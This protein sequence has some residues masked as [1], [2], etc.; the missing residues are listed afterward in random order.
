MVGSI[1]TN[2]Q[3]KIRQ[4]DK[5]ITEYN[6][7]IS[8]LEKARTL[9][10]GKKSRVVLIETGQLYVYRHQ[11]YL[12]RLKKETYID[13]LKTK[14]RNDLESYTWLP[15]EDYLF[16]QT[17]KTFLRGEI[18][19]YEWD[20]DYGIIYQKNNPNIL[21]AQDE[22]LILDN[23]ITSREKALAEYYEQPIPITGSHITLSHPLPAFPNTPTTSPNKSSN[24]V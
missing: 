15:N 1:A 17:I 23:V 20:Y 8:V 22:A 13:K 5:Q 2:Q 10:R 3:A 4:M 14:L 12:N 18:P 11:T 7:Y 6:K 21:L 19:F 9:F 16:D 24:K